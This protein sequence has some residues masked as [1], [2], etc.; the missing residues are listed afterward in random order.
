MKENFFVIGDIHG[1]FPELEKMLQY[2]DESTEQLIFLGDYI[3][4]GPDSARVLTLVEQLVKDKGAIALKGNH[5]DMLLDFLSNPL[6]AAEHY[7]GQ[8]GY[9]TMM[10]FGYK[11]FEPLYLAGV[12]SKEQTEHL[13]FIQQLPLYHE[14]E[15]LLFVH[16]GINPRLRNWQDTSPEDFVWIRD[17]FHYSENSVE[18][19]IV[20]GHTPVRTLNLD[21]SDIPWTRDN[22]IGLD[23]GICYKQGKLFGA[24]FDSSG[25]MT[26]IHI[27]QKG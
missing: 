21:G 1:H 27:I 7:L 12:F 11:G 20:F 4:R 13:A 25:Q 6:F 2:W 22:K 5:E 14:T 10:S 18:K 9:Q 8:G 16:A 3:D 26:A 24:R 15:K 19:T 23:G 17:A